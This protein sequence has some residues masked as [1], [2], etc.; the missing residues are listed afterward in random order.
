[1]T[2]RAAKEKD[3]PALSALL[4]QLGYPST[5]ASCREKVKVYSKTGYKMLVAEID[6][7]VVGFI[8]LHHYV[9]PH[10]PGPTGRITAFCLD[11]KSRGRGLGTLLLEASELYF[12]EVG[13]YKVEVTSNVKR[14]RTHSYY[15]NLGYQQT[16]MHFAKFLKDH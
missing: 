15:L 12:K 16:S 5:D 13:C 14:T 6:L 11:E 10:L 4:A 9:T 2:I 7:T 3:A 8:S 1:M